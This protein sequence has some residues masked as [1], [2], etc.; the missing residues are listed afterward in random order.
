MAGSNEVAKLVEGISA[1]GVQAVL[2]AI[3][4]IVKRGEDV[5]VKG[6]G[7]FSKKHKEARMGR[8]P[9]TGEE[10]QISAKDVLHF[11]PSKLITFEVPKKTNRSR[12]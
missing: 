6:F 8:N 11:K 9:A 12:N 10:V 2:E 1:T 7:T 3:L 5:N 4:E